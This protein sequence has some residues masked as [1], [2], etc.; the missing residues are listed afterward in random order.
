MPVPLVDRVAQPEHADRQIEVMERVKCTSWIFDDSPAIPV[1]VASFTLSATCSGSTANPP[2]KSAFTGT[3]TA[4][5][6]SRR[7]SS[8]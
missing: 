5:A 8:T 3:L 7:C 2:S 6:T 1:A 4:A